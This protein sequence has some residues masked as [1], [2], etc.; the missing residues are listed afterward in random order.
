MLIWFGHGLFFYVCF[1]NSADQN[2]TEMALILVVAAPD[3]HTSA[4]M[5]ELLV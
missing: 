4:T 2:K 5:F 3:H 1:M